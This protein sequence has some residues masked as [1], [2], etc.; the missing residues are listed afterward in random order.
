[1]AKE[2]TCEVLKNYLDVD[3]GD[4]Y[5]TR[6]CEVKWNGRE[7]KGYDIRK[8]NIEQDKLFKGITISYNGF[9][10]LIYGAIENG[11][12]DIDEVQR[13]IDKRK[14]Q[15]LTMDDFQNIFKNMNKEN[16]EF[17]RDKYGH[18]RTADGLYVIS[19]RRNAKY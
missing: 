12:V 14:C 19:R 1:M 15:I 7:P 11:L 4:E 16:E 5:T 13:R 8:Y 10:D 17:I 2:I 9:K 3:A 6:L 18:L